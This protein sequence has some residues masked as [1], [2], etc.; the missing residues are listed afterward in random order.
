MEVEVEKYATSIK[1]YSREQLYEECISWMRNSLD[2]KVRDIEKDKAFTAMSKAFQN[3]SDEAKHYKSL[4]FE[5][6]KKN[7]VLC[8]QNS[9]L[10]R[11]RFGSRN[12]KMNGPGTD[13]DALQD[14]LSEYT[15]QGET[16]C[17]SENKETK[18]SNKGDAS[19]NKDKSGRKESQ[20]P[21][22]AFGNDR[23]KKTPT[24][25][26]YSQLPHRDNYLIDIDKLNELYGVGN[27]QIINW[28]DKELLHRLPTVYYVEVRHTP[29]V[30]DMRTGK[31]PSTP[32]PDV[33]L[34]RSSVTSSLVAGIMYDMAVNASPYYRQHVDMSNCGLILPRQDMD[35]WVL[36]FS[37]SHLQEPYKHLKYLL[38]QRPVSQCDETYDL[39]LNEPG[40]KATTKSF[41]WVHTNGEFDEGPPIAIYCYEETRGTKHLRE[42]YAHFSGVLVSDA[43]VSYDTFAD[44]TNGKVVSAKCFMHARRYYFE[45]LVVMDAAKMTDEQYEQ[46]PEVI[47]IRKIAGIYSL[48]GKFKSLSPAERLE[49]RQKEVKPLIDDFFDFLRSLDLSSPRLSSKMQEAVK[50]SLNH[51]TGLRRFLDDG[52]VP[53]DNGYCEN[54]IR[55]FARGRRNWLFSSSPAGAEAKVIV[56][57]LVET[58]QRNDANPLIYLTYLLENAPKFQDTDYRDPR[59]DALMPWSPEYKEYESKKFNELIDGLLPPSQERPPYKPGMDLGPAELEA[60]A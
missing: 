33:L 54:A 41:V 17:E 58:A 56:Y 53:L 4:Y 32:M 7:G 12:E 29:V 28:H 9:L 11:D 47:A 20:S 13:D 60:S 22:N 30:K 52:R 3:V 31:L 1:P 44:E 35:N 16:D 48:E 26:D 25:R 19:G 39:V 57:S 6:K 10:L 45:A 21:R 2:Q 40:R 5:E 51:E 24:R 46:Q 23:S 14:P 38:G 36:R 43:Y 55:P 50:Y 27:W 42:F 37:H 49:R 15:E 18:P 34:P 8:E 59:M